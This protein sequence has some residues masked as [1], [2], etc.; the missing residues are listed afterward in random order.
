MQGA[1]VWGSDVENWLDS[2]FAETDLLSTIIDFRSSKP[3][4]VRL[5]ALSAS[6]LRQVV[7]AISMIAH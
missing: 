6:K 5:G 3:N 4:I 2:G 1:E 7:P